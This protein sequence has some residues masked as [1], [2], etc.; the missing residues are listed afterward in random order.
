[1]CFRL[2]LHQLY[3][4]VSRLPSTA[5]DTSSDLQ[6][7]YSYS[8]DTSDTPGTV[9]DNRII[10]PGRI[11]AALDLHTHSYGS[12][13]GGL[14]LNEYRRMLES[15]KL[16][17]VAITDHGSIKT[18]QDIQAKLGEL[19]ERIIIGE[20]IKTTDG[21]IIGLY[22]NES[23]PEGM[24]PAE[25]VVAIRAQAALV[26]V[27]HPF[28]KIRSG[29]S[30]AGLASILPDVDIVESFNGRAYGRNPEKK[31]RELT[32]YVDN[33]HWSY[34]A[35]SDAHGGIGWGR[36]YSIVDT[37]PTKDSLVTLMKSASYSRKRV[38]LGILYPKVNRIHKIH[39]T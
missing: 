21:E 38:G 37:L 17:V 8:S 36:T 26:Y 15:G 27:P 10:H 12:P 25:T 30:K 24:T 29:M 23:I 18:A 16:D 4:G 11:G 31:L 1:M 3:Q 39:A 34:A 7:S 13:D 35:S 20:E 33:I 2:V 19:G 22:L 14:S 32:D 5:P 6:S 9:A 28:E